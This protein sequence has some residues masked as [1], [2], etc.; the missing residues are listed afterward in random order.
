MKH[1]MTSSQT[2][3]AQHF[4][5]ISSVSPDNYALGAF[6]PHFFHN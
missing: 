1:P 2:A 3:D 5:V 6:L 4:V